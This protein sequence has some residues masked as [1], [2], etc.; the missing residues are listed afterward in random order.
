MPHNF[1]DHRQYVFRNAEKQRRKILTRRDLLCS[2]QETFRSI[3][4]N[5][6]QQQD[7]AHFEDMKLIWL[8]DRFRIAEPFYL[9]GLTMEELAQF[10]RIFGPL[11]ATAYEVHGQLQGFMH[12]QQMRPVQNDLFSRELA[13]A[14]GA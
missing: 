2:E 12:T 1:R 4:R 14:G 8:D 13:K 10:A 11:A 6:R 5:S 3:I 7:E 9:W